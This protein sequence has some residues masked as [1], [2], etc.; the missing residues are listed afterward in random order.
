MASYK[1]STQ[2]KN[3][4]TACAV[5]RDLGISTK[6]GVEICRWL[7]YRNLYKAKNLLQMV[8]DK[9]MAVPYFRFNTDVGHKP[10]IK[11]GRFPFN[12]S[13]EIL[14]LLNSAEKN[15]VFKNLEIENLKIVHI[16][17]QKASA[18]TQNGRHGGR[19]MKRTHVEVVLAES[20]PVPKGAKKIQSQKPAGKEQ[21]VIG[22]KEVKASENKNSGKL[23]EKKE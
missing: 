13:K 1:Y 4:Q 5:G 11:S 7:R 17:A 2:L 3:E 22:S 16:N 23:K 12:A 8:M 20:Q 6:A 19:V 10:G 14:S 21:P 18:P 15:A 9:K